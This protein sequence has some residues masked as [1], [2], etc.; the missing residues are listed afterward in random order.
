[1]TRNYG[2]GALDSELFEEEK[3]CSGWL[4]VV[5]SKKKTK[6]KAYKRAKNK[7]TKEKYFK[8]VHCGSISNHTLYYTFSFD[9]IYLFLIVPVSLLNYYYLFY[10]YDNIFIINKDNIMKLLFSFLY[11]SLIWNVFYLFFFFFIVLTFV[12]FHEHFQYSHVNN[13]SRD[14]LSVFYY[15]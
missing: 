15:G 4:I 5:T 9:T 7:Q 1:M 11:L 8:K 14:C 13:Y 12:Y 10:I 3:S 6:L 2:Q